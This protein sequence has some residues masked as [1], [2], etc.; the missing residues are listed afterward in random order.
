MLARPEPR[1]H[2]QLVRAV[3]D[4]QLPLAG[5]GQPPHDIRGARQ[6]L[7]LVGRR[8]DLPAAALH[9][10]QL[11][12]DVGS[13]THGGDAAPPGGQHLFVPV[14]VRPD[15]H[16]A[17]NM[18]QDDGQFRYGLGEICQLWQLREVKKNI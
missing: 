7:D 3:R 2:A 4:V 13:C 1:L 12:D 14:S 5:A 6:Q 8:Q 10:T 17:S 18:V 16:Q 11:D 15:P 9:P